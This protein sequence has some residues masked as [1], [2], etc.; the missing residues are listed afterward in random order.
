MKIT[1]LIKQQQSITTHPSQRPKFKMQAMSK[2]RE[3]MEQE[4]LLIAG[5]NAKWYSI[6]T[7]EDSLS[8]SY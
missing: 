2:A 7:L 5:E 6:A 8:V 4:L 1:V 3:D